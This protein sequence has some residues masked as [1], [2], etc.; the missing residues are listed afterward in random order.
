M[1]V[2]VCTPASWQQPRVPLPPPSRPGSTSP[3]LTSAAAFTSLAQACRRPAPPRPA[4][5][6]A[7]WQHTNQTGNAL[8]CS[9]LGSSRRRTLP[10]S[11][12]LSETK[13]PCMQKEQTEYTHHE[14][15]QTQKETVTEAQI[16]AET[17]QHKRTAQLMCVRLVPSLSCAV[18]PSVSFPALSISN[19]LN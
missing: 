5:P 13:G 17:V 2:C 4:P 12:A 9:C 14:N 1:C 7:Q 15:S 8:E 6:P 19:K 3:F 10:E 16:P 11:P 18:W